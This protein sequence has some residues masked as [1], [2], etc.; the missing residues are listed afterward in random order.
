[1]LSSSSLED[2]ELKTGKTGN[3]EKRETG[4]RETGKR[5]KSI[6]GYSG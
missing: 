6:T 2:N 4:K 5:V 1:L 3:W